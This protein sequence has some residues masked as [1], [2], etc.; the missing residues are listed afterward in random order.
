LYGRSTTILEATAPFRVNGTA[1]LQSL[2]HG[3]RVNYGNS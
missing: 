2:Y 3:K 1:M